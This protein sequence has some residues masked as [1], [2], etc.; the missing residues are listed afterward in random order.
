MVLDDWSPCSKALSIVSLPT[1]NPKWTAQ[2]SNCR[3][4]SETL[5]NNVGC[6]MTW[7]TL[8]GFPLCY[9]LQLV[10]LWC[11]KIVC[12]CSFILYDF[13]N[14]CANIYV[15]ICSIT[16]KAPPMLWNCL[17]STRY[18]EHQLLHHINCK[19]LLYWSSSVLNSLVMS[20]LHLVQPLVLFYVQDDRRAAQE[21]LP[22]STL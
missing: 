16:C 21:K 14:V 22:L 13:V 15:A 7:V 19:H 4:W 2:G 5:L 12:V 1:R 11:V 9:M 17:F 3:L 6:D 18:S 10:V 8:H 20:T